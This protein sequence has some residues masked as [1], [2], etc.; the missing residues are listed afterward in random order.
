LHILA[1]SDTFRG[2]Q[3]L[4][5]ERTPQQGFASDAAAV[6]TNITVTLAELRGA[7]W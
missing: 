2:A 1:Q 3:L 4:K 7:D 5:A 6:L